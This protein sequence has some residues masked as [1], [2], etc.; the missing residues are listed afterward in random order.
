MSAKVYIIVRQSKNFS[1]GEVFEQTPDGFYKLDKEPYRSKVT[2]TLAW[3][4]KRR[5]PKIALPFDSVAPYVIE[6]ERT[7]RRH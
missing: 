5:E 3:K 7:M 1:I 4:Y 2:G 6:Q